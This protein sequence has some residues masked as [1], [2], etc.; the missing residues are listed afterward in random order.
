M[1][2]KQL[3]EKEM[4]EKQFLQINKRSSFTALF[5]LVAILFASYFLT[6]LIPQGE[7]VTVGGIREYQLIEPRQSYSFG[8]F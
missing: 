8:K 1:D 3:P 4:T 2:E 5:I 7:Y 6:L